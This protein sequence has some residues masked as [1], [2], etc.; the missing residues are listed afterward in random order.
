MKK[1][2]SLAIAFI[3][4]AFPLQTNTKQKV[5]VKQRV[6]SAFTK[7][8]HIVFTP[9]GLRMEF[10]ACKKKYCPAQQFGTQELQA[11][12]LNHCKETY[13]KAV[14]KRNINAVAAGT[15]AGVIAAIP[16]SIA[17]TM[18]YK[19]LVESGAPTEKQEKKAERLVGKYNLTPKQATMFYTY[20]AVPNAFQFPYW[21]KLSDNFINALAEYYYGSTNQESL[22]KIKEQIKVVPRT[23]ERQESPF[24]LIKKGSSA[25][26]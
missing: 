6:K 8:K 17:M 21:F 7:A 4:A 26:Q 9:K 10:D 23:G 13:K 11:C 1:G 24:Y 18:G 2:Y 14:A 22:D 3:L 12:M 19:A 15:A 20:I 25:K 16:L 5:D